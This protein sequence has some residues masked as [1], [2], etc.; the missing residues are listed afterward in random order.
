M[1]NLQDLKVN[2]QNADIAPMVL[3]LTMFETI[4]GNVRGSMT[5]KII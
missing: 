2:V 4:K 5:V 1:I 3:S